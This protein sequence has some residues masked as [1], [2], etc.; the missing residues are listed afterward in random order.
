MKTDY[1]VAVVGAGNSALVA[2]LSACEAGAKVVV[3]E[4]APKAKRGGNT[5]FTGG[6]FRF[7]ISGLEEVRELA[8]DLSDAEAAMMDMPAYTQDRFYS[9]IM[10]LSQGLADPELAQT[11]VTRSNQTIRWMAAQGVRGYRKR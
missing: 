2:A 7:V 11:L 8:P 1:D 9:V 3:L 4:A 6:G 10:R 5:Y